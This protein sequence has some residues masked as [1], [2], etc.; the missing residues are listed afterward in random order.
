MRKTPTPLLSGKT[1]SMLV[2]SGSD[3]KKAVADGIA[4]NLKSAQVTINITEAAPDEFEAAVKSGAYDLYLGETA[5]SRTMDPTFL[6]KT[7][8]SMNYLGFSDEGL[9]AEYEK[10]KNGE[11]SLSEYLSAFSEKMPLIP[12]VFRKKCYVLR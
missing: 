3:I 9:D 6:Y 8:G 5:I 7:G 12:V 1:F 4:E 10:L 11:I 2:P